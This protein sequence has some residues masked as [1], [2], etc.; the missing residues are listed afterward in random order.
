MAATYAPLVE[1]VAR[2]PQKFPRG[3]AYYNLVNEPVLVLGCRVCHGGMGSGEFL[4]LLQQGVHMS[5][6]GTKKL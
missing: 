2:T 1:A 5:L 3:V 4:G 6:P